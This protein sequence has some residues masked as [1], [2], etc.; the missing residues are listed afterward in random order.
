MNLWNHSSK[1]KWESL[2][3]VRFWNPMDCIVH[4]ILQARIL[5]WVAFPFS[6]GPSQPRYW[7]QVSHIAGRFFTSWATR[8]VQE[9]WS[10]WP[11]LSPAD[12]PDPGIEPGS[13]ASRD[14]LWSKGLSELPLGQWLSAFFTTVQSTYLIFYIL[15]STHMCSARMFF[16]LVYSTQICSIPSHSM[17]MFKVQLESKGSSMVP[18]RL[19]AAAWEIPLDLMAYGCSQPIPDHS[20][21]IEFSNF[22][23]WNAE[24]I[25]VSVRGII[26]F[27]IIKNF[28][29]CF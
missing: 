13:P 21:C 20:F 6:R 23:I 12:L 10:G 24:Y 22:F 2:S 25:H 18:S 15:F 19:Q 27:L 26:P 29:K 28:F 8:E 4:G 11:S 7:N 1:W 16:P 9:Y 14:I 3:H 17:I 5:E